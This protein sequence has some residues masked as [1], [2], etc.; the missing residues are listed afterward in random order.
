MVPPLPYLTFAPDSV[1][2]LPP[3]ST[4]KCPLTKH[5]PTCS[6]GLISLFMEPYSEGLERIRKFQTCL[7]AASCSSHRWSG[8]SGSHPALSPTPGTPHTAL[9]PPTH[10][11]RARKSEFAWPPAQR[12]SKS[13]SLLA[14]SAEGFRPPAPPFQPPCR[15]P[16]PP[17]AER[18]ASLI[19]SGCCSFIPQQ[20]HR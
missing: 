15:H 8:L 1:H 4:P 18:N 14:T 6:T 2:C 17:G 11:Q 16:G 5:I 19:R 7:H 10:A 9:F 12:R 3:C 13:W 20:T